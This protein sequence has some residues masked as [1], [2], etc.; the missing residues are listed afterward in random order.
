MWQYQTKGWSCALKSLKGQLD[1]GTDFYW[2]W[3]ADKFEELNVEAQAAFADTY[4]SGGF[5][6]DITSGRYKTTNG[7]VSAKLVESMLE[8]LQN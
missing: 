5:A 2:D 1:R 6:F 4:F 7:V 3:D 8:A